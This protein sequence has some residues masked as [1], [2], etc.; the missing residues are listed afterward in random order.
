MLLASAARELDRLRAR[1]PGRASALQPHGRGGDAW[2]ALSGR[3]RRWVG[4][5]HVPL[6]GF[7][8]AL[9]RPLRRPRPV[10][11]RHD[12][13]RLQVRGPLH[14]VFSG[15]AGL[16][17]L[18]AVRG[19]HHGCHP[20]AVLETLHAASGAHHIL[21]REVFRR[22]S[23]HSV[24][25]AGLGGGRLEWNWL[26]VGGQGR[27]SLLQYLRRIRRGICVGSYLRGR[28]SGRGHEWT[29]HLHLALHGRPAVHPTI[30]GGSLVGPAGA[31][32]VQVRGPYQAVHARPLLLRAP[33]GAPGG[34]SA[35]VLRRHA[36]W[37]PPQDVPIASAA[38]AE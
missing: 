38:T 9:P 36:R 29:I 32:A 25:A 34:L 33:H 5:L 4:L 26:Q 17:A 22:S 21:A 23:S 18:H 24:R 31:A 27:R 37:A 2:H 15:S 3:G 11:K 1:R 8:A 13:G 12:A 35:G 6:Q 20:F 10:R 14:G 19:G 16:L 28:D 30:G 7:E